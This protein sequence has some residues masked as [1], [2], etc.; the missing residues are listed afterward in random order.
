MRLL[1]RLKHLFALLLVGGLVPPA[2]AATQLDVSFGWDGSVRT[3]RWTPIFISA[4]DIKPRQALIEFDA[5]QAGPYVMRLRQYITLGPQP[6]TVI[7]YAPASERYGDPPVVV[8]RDADSGKL[9]ARWPADPDS[10]TNA[11]ENTLS[12]EQK[13]VGVTGPNLRLANFEQNVGVP[14]RYAGIRPELLPDQPV[15]YDPLDLLV[16]NRADLNTIEPSRQQAI[17]DWVRTGGMLLLWP[18]DTPTPADSP[19]GRILPC[20][21]GGPKNY[22][23]T[24]QQR[25]K[26]G[27]GDRF[28]GMMGFALSPT[29]DAEAID[30]MPEDAAGAKLT[31]Y[32]RD[33]GF[34]R[35]VVAPININELLFDRSDGAKL[36]HGALLK[37]VFDSEARNQSNH[38]Y[39]ALDPASQLQQGAMSDLQDHLAN[40]PGAG[41]FGFSYVVWVV[42]GMMAVVGPVDWFVLRK[43][44]RQPWTWVT[45]A[46]W[47][48]L[49][50]VGALFIGKVFK[51]GDLHYRT[52]TLIDQAGD[53]VV[54][55]TT[56][57]GIYSP[58]TT[59]Y[60]IDAAPTRDDANGKPIPT[61]QPPTGWWEPASAMHS[62][63]GGGM[64]LDVPFRQT[65]EGNQPQEMTINV[66]NMRA[67]RG[68]NLV[69]GEPFIKADLRCRPV[70]SDWRVSGTIANRSGQPLKDIRIAVREGYVA[71]A[72]GPPSVVPLAEKDS[73]Y[74]DSRGDTRH[75]KLTRMLPLI[76]RVDPGK[77]V[78]IDGVVKAVSMTPTDGSGGNARYY[79]ETPPPDPGSVWALATGLSG[80][81]AARADEAVSD[82]TH[83]VIY[84][85]VDNPRPPVVLRGN[86]PAIERHD[87]VVRA[88]VRLTAAEK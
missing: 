72:A 17:A 71:D 73:A 58:R 23:F 19:I 64:K 4:S 39:Y 67:L 41:R 22:A 81:R 7:L 11:Y 1:L 24:D 62:Y 20:R 46:G 51:S 83:A 76:Q 26:A 43:L 60:Y 75:I 63:G 21:V 12:A 47:I 27:L 35:V 86:E 29:A 42:L 52:V 5:P 55:R 69:A 37:G 40:V 59:D 28:K 66:W 3:G 85:I 79:S 10:G 61:L 74:R 33:H 78:E 34:G 70:G 49:I 9:L 57:A 50:T 31:A 53:Q 2:L 30:L 38:G 16:L 44:G 48:G 87:T 54:A 45:T 25:I 84:A 13:F 88:L 8:L 15:G 80:R 77:T 6:T 36:L 56:L 18:S 68:E 14:M 82:G 32:A 65:T